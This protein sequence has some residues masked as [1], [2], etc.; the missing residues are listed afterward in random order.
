MLIAGHGAL[1]AVPA[2]FVG[3]GL[4]AAG[5]VGLHAAG[6][7]AGV[8]GTTGGGARLTAA[9]TGP[10][11]AEA[12][13][14]LSSGALGTG[15]LVG[16]AAGA[17]PVLYAAGRTA[18]GWAEARRRRNATRPISPAAPAP[19]GRVP[20]PPPPPTPT[21]PRRPM[22]RIVRG[23]IRTGGNVAGA[24]AGEANAWLNPWNEGRRVRREQLRANIRLVRTGNNPDGSPAT[25]ADR[26]AA[27][28]KL[29][30]I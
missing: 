21:P 22:P 1:P 24:V 10:S 26:Q 5:A 29:F 27:S 30:T 4:A 20:T 14:P 12:I 13:G 28:R 18:R 11:G 19:G 9:V 15:E 25:P 16:M 7:G 2:A 3:A 17:V 6:V 23:A 8:H